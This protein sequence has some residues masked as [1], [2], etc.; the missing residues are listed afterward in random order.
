MKKL[1]NNIGELS[2]DKID[3]EDI[4]KWSELLTRFDTRKS[5][6]NKAQVGTFKKVLYLKSYNTIVASIYNNNIRVYGFFSQTTN[7][8]IQEFALQNGFDKIPLQ[9]IKNTCVYSK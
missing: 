5:F 9:D 7:R 1:K 8:H 4:K 2:I 6:Y 3:I